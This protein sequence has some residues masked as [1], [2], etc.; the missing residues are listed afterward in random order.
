MSADYGSRAPRKKTR[1]AWIVAVVVVLVGLTAAVFVPSWIKQRN[2]AIV[3]SGMLALQAPPCPT[4]S[5]AEFAKGYSTP[6]GLTF[7]EVRF[8]RQHGHAS[9]LDLRYD[10]GKGRGTYPACQF[11]SP[12][13]LTVES[14]KGK[15]HF[16]PGLGKDATVFVEHGQ[17]RCVMA[18]NKALF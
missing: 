4:L 6:K 3:D 12:A 16:Q 11:M 18:I 1:Y 10:G 9:C 2:Q 15:F 17:P 13:V 14:D 7:G 8:E 5:E